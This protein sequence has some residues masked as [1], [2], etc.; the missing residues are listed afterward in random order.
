MFFCENCRYSF[1]VTKDVKNKQ[2]GGKINDALN[3]IFQKF[4]SNSQIIE[5][6]LAK[7]KG[8]D[9]TD[10]ERFENMTKKD[11]KKLMSQIK[12]INKNF[13]IEDKTGGE[14]VGTTKAY[15]TCKYCDNYKPIQPGT[16]IYT[17]NYDISGSDE[18]EDYSKYINDYT[19]NRTKSYICKNKSC[20]SHTDD[21][22]KEAVLTK[23]STDQIVYICKACSTY[24]INAL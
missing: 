7:I 17:K 22:V 6:D 4:M 20:K 3:N 16:L 21:T 1:N 19:L 10:D 11:Q 18:I 2:V 12:N 24:W 9:I 23:N 5:K 15:F 8:R 13:F 14:P